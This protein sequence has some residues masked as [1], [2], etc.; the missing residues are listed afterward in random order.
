MDE[1]LK[2][3]IAESPIPKKVAIRIIAFEEEVN[4]SIATS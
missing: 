4:P 3:Q 1:R 2:K